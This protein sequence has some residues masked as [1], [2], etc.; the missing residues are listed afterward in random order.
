MV[1]G[2]G[3]AA[4]AL[5][6]GK[7]RWAWLGLRTGL[8]MCGK[9]HT[10]PG[11][12]PRT[13]QPVVSPYTDWAIPAGTKQYRYFVNKSEI[14]SYSAIELSSLRGRTYHPHWHTN[15]HPAFRNTYCYSNWWRGA[16]QYCVI[17]IQNSPYTLQRHASFHQPLRANLQYNETN[18][19]DH[20]AQTL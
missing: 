15:K 3:H 20:M 1:G 12:D 11:F 14:L 9:S 4:A 7:T 6:L 8:D 18:N 5:L 16:T 19:T 13:V 10:L 2:Q 17:Q